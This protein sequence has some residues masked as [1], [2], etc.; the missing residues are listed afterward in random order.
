MGRGH[1]LLDNKGPN[2]SSSDDHLISERLI[3][4]FE[5]FISNMTTSLRATRCKHPVCDGCFSQMQPSMGII[6]C[7]IAELTSV[8]AGA[9][10]FD[11]STQSKWTE[12]R[13]GG[14]LGS[15]TLAFPH[16][17]YFYISNYNVKSRYSSS[18]DR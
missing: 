16:K 5:D 18:N 14:T 6:S 13:G 9:T 11:S 17:K 12:G 1:E 3:S 7:P 8:P 15:P 2:R 10:F 4:R